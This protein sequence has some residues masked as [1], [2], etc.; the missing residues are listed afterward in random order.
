[1][2]AI[3][4]LF[5]AG[6]TNIIFLLFVL[7]SCRCMGIWKFGKN[8]FNNKKFQKFYSFHCYYWY[9]FI[10]SVLIHTILAFYLFGWPGA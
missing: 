6:I 1:M 5:I 2:N 7:F 8:W 9:G 4:I 10:I 3:Q